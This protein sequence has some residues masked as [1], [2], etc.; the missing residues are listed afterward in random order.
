MTFFD[1]ILY[2][3]GFALVG[4][5]FGYLF[6]MK[7]GLDRAAVVIEHTVNSD[8]PEESQCR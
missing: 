2:A 8:A 3:I 4:G 5:F 7:A 6:G 1:F